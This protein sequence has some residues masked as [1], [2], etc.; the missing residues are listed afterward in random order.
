MCPVVQTEIARSVGK[1]I[2]EEIIKK[3]IELL[4]N[5]NANRE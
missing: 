2:D 1:I 3:L 5:A 4:G